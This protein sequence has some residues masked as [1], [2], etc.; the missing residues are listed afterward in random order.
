M[1]ANEISIIH[2][3][4]KLPL[5]LLLLNHYKTKGKGLHLGNFNLIITNKRENTTPRKFQAEN[6]ATKE[7]SN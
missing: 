7:M 1:R 4:M 6:K 3:I 2:V 5:N